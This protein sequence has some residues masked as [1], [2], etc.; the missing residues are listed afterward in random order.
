MNDIT[1]HVRARQF[2]KLYRNVQFI[3]EKYAML[4]QL[5]EIGGVKKDRHLQS[6]GWLIGYAC[7]GIRNNQ[8]K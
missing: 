8:A 1:R 4:L 2:K 6:F 7:L 3:H 5:C